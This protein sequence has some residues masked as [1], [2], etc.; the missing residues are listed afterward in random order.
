MLRAAAPGR[1][2]LHC[3]VPASSL[4]R[5]ARRRSDHF[6]VTVARHKAEGRKWPLVLGMTPPLLTIYISVAC[7]HQ[8]QATGVRSDNGAQHELLLGAP[9]GP[10]T[11]LCALAFYCIHLHAPLHPKPTSR[12][13]RDPRR[14]AAVAAVASA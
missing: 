12:G 6:L 8:W 11:A 14:A 1:R 9:D 3:G 7:H 10:I 13:Q 2:Q 5:V 4:A